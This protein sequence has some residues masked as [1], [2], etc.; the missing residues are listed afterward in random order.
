MQSDTKVIN[1]SEFLFRRLLEPV[2]LE[3]LL[4]PVLFALGVVALIALFRRE[5]RLAFLGIGSAVVIGLSLPYFGFILVFPQLRD[6]AGWR[7][8]LAPVLTVA[9]VYIAIMY[10]RD[11]QTI[12]P[13]LAAMLGLMRLTVY[14]ILALVFLLPGFQNYN[15]FETQSRILVIFDVSDSMNH[16]DD[17][18]LPG[19]VAQK[20]PTRQD[21]VL[22]IFTEP[23]ADGRGGDELNLIERL[24]AKS[25]VVVYRFG[26]EPDPE[27]EFFDSHRKWTPL[28]WRAFLHPDPKTIM[29]KKG[30]TEVE[31]QRYVDDRKFLYDRLLNSTDL[32]GSVLRI[33][34]R[35]SNNHIQAVIVIS[36]GQNN[37][38]SE[39]AYRQIVNWASNPRKPVQ[40]Y[41]VGI[42]NY[43]QPTRIRLNPLRAPSTIRPD[44][45]NLK[46]VVP[47]FGDGLPNEKVTVKLYATRIEDKDQKDLEHDRDPKGNLV[48]KDLSKETKLVDTKEFKFSGGEFPS[49]EAEFIVNLAK[50]MEIDP[51]KDP[52]GRL[53]G[54]WRFVAK[55]PRHPKENFVDEEHVSEPG[56]IVQVLEKQLKVLIVA[57]GPSRD[58]QFARTMFHREAQQDRMSLALYLQTAKDDEDVHQDV[59][60][61]YLLTQFPNKL[62]SAKEK[63]DDPYNLKRYDVIIGFDVNWAALDVRQIELLSRWST[64]E[65]GGLIFVAGDV[66]T[67]KL[68]TPGDDADKLK[69][70][71][72]L[73]PVTLKDSR[74]EEAERAAKGLPGLKRDAPTKLFF[75][76]AA[77][78][79]FVNL[80]GEKHWDEFFNPKDP[81]EKRGFYRAQPIESKSII[82]KTVAEFDIEGGTPYF[83]LATPQGKGKTFYIGGEESWRLKVFN[84]DLY[85]KFWLKVAAYVS[86]GSE[87][88]KQGKI[89]MAEEY[90]VGQIKIEAE[91]RDAEGNLADKVLRPEVILKRPP[92]FNKDI[93]AV[94]PEGFKLTAK[95]PDAPVWGGIFTHTFEVK[96]TGVY[97]VQVKVPGS[98][99]TISHTFVVKPLNV[100]KGNP[101]T[102]FLSLYQM[103]TEAR[104]IS[105][106]LSGDQ[107]KQFEDALRKAQQRVKNTDPKDQTQPLRLFFVED[108]ARGIHEYVEQLPPDRQS[109]KGQFK[110][111]W[112]QGW[113][114]GPDGLV[115]PKEVA[116][117]DWQNS[118]VY[119]KMALMRKHGLLEPV[120]VPA[121]FLLL[122]PAVLGGFMCMLLLIS[123]R[124][125]ALGVVGGSTL[126]VMLALLVVIA[127]VWGV[128]GNLELYMMMSS[129]HVMLVVALVVA[130]VAVLILLV[131]NRWIAAIITVVVTALL[132]A[133]LVGI[134]AALR[135]DWAAMPLH[136]S[137]VL[138]AVVGLLSLE[139]LSR[140]LLKL[141]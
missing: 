56:K 43:V 114:P 100:E 85:Q 59:E 46:V 95:D 70:L 81:S 32:G 64:E 116:A 65:K 69:P 67:D 15:T 13:V 103:S 83:V 78:Y 104:S 22:K 41:T 138:L 4:F 71:L 96:T 135:P 84:K 16:Q 47:L 80:D 125:M 7:L 72:A 61:K 87:T 2:P 136:M 139:W 98:T 92:E 29:P 62:E 58:Y 60:A 75:K 115:K 106:R 128:A 108:Q 12:N 94:T 38:G 21:K 14:V 93:D 124:W 33:T 19:Q 112:D 35:E 17:L 73:L 110:E 137:W 27:G 86:S 127:S 8:V 52:E 50:V 26:G 91:V 131:I 53:Q 9:L 102:N 18:P 42:G 89:F 48:K 105:D 20:R 66:Y 51:K 90:V 117:E 34:Q 79:P 25:N 99:E 30:M 55:V 126:A 97:T 57:G 45:E 49:V 111:I 129:Y 24:Q 101:K 74:D 123:G 122:I 141:A 63:L 82:A 140:K 121:M 23:Y 120:L 54:K 134:N 107:R 11:A 5:H 68:A 39:E 113:K 109:T 130:A 88:R 28:E 133:G 37:R 76:D 3:G 118:D 77:E 1:E 6:L 132:V 31:A 40:V 119:Q 10:F 36:D 44:D